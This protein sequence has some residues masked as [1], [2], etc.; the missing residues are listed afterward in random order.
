MNPYFN[1]APIG[2]IFADRAEAVTVAPYKSADYFKYH[3]AL[4][5]AVTRVFDGIEDQQ[6]AWDNYVVEVEAF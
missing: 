4:Q 2:S 1:D 3:Q 5:D 6:T